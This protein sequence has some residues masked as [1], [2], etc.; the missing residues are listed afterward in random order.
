MSAP[1]NRWVL[2]TAAYAALLTDGYPP[3][4]FDAGEHELPSPAVIEGSAP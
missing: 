3:F 1:S 4:R 2:P